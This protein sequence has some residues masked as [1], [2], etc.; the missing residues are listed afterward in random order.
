MKNVNRPEDRD[1]FFKLMYTEHGL[2]VLDNYLDN[3]IE[4]YINKTEY[5]F[6]LGITLGLPMYGYSCEVKNKDEMLGRIKILMSILG[7]KEKDLSDERRI[8]I[9][10]ME[11]TK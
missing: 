11:E 5:P 10:K 8:L 6:R 1:E 3:L 2:K 9:F 7:L 4:E